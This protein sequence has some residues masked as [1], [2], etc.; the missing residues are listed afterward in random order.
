MEVAL[1]SAPAPAV[2]VGSAYTESR[3]ARDDGYL[4][5]IERKRM[6]A[7][8][9]IRERMV[10]DIATLVHDGGEAA[11]VTQ[12]DLIRLGWPPASVMAHATHAFAAFRNLGRR[13]RDRSLSPGRLAA[14]AFALSLFLAS[15]TLIAGVT[16]GAI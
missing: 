6:V 7:P 4:W 8:G 14:E 16:A 11:V 12:D 15:V 10:E 1:L 5:P 9:A 3:V 13:G 2:P